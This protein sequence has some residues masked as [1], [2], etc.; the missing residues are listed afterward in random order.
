MSS[1]TNFG[2]CSTHQEATKKIDLCILPPVLI[3]SLKRFRVR[4][5]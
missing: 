1:L 2:F 5:K 3:V 4:E